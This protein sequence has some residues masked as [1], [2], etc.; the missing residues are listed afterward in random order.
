H[1][2]AVLVVG[3]RDQPPLRA[4]PL[5]DRQGEIGGP[6]ADHRASYRH[7]RLQRQDQAPLVA[8]RLSSES[9]ALVS[10]LAAQSRS[11]W[12]VPVV[13]PS[14]LACGPTSEAAW[15][16]GTTARPNAICAKPRVAGKK[17]PGA[18]GL[19]PGER[20]PQPPEM[21]PLREW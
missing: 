16:H 14:G 2:P 13:A 11:R 21:R 12:A 5:R 6:G 9:A 18:S 20:I 15:G 4:G 7:R 10:P 1:Q 19:D 17:I 3:Q 8:Y